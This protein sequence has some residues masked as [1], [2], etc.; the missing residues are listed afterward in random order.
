MYMTS[1]NRVFL[2]TALILAASAFATAQVVRPPVPRASQKSTVAQTIGTTD[3][4]ITYS[5]PAVKGRPIFGDPPAAMASRAKGEATLDDQN[6]RQKG[7]PIV[8]WDH[9]WR[10]GA[11]EATLFTA[12]D[13]VLINGQLLPAGKYSLHMLP[14][15]DGNWMVIFNKDDGQ[16]GSFTYD[17]A[18]DALRVKTKAEPAPLNMELLTYY[19]DPVGETQATVHLRWEKMDV[20]FT[21]EVKDVVG[22]TM[23]RLRAYVAAAKADDPGPYA[24]AAGY[25]KSVKLN[26][27]ANKWFEEALK[28]TDAQIAVKETYQN[29]LRRSNILLQLGRAS[30]SLATAEHAIVVGKAANVDTSA[31]EKRIADMKA[32]KQ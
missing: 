27:E 20:P 4:S 28:R 16:W 5:R 24:N 7:E 14:A 32:G 9:V 11:N 3:V 30:E 31:L 21:V 2:S 22:S 23:N 8:P 19:F 26:D 12:N 29:L 1:L 10:A 17:A 18:K 25:A 13:D 15:K 6:A